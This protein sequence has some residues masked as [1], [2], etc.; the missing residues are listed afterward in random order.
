MNLYP[1]VAFH[2]RVSFGG[3]SS[4]ADASFQKV[5]GIGAKMETE[6]VVEGG[7]NAF[8][9]RLPKKVSHDN[10]VLERGIAD[11]DSDLVS[12]CQETM[13]GGLGS[14]KPRLVYVH[15]LDSE[16]SPLHAWTFA[17]AYPVRWQVGDFNAQENKVAVETIELA[18]SMWM[19]EI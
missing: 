11:M 16:R 13:A 7:E 14:I 9:H 1:P 18:Y 2:F 4:A 10:L 15:L 17:N 12:W 3:V 19:R 6:E 8:V 5:S